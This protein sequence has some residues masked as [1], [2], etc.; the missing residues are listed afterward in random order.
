MTAVVTDLPLRAWKPLAGLNWLCHGVLAL[1]LMAPSMT[2]VVRLGEA[3]EVVRAAG[4]LPE[5]ETYSVLSGI[6]ALFDHGNLLIGLLLLSFS[7]L[8]PVAKLVVVRLT[9]Q[10]ARSGIAPRRLLAAT[11]MF[12]K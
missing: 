12:S 10:G 3:T 7:V 11:A 2:V 6:L 8:F 1:G 5:P 4:I 9:L